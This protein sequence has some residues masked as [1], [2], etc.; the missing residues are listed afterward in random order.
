MAYLIP[1]IGFLFALGIGI[2]GEGM[3]PIRSE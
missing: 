3:L 2:L 1:V